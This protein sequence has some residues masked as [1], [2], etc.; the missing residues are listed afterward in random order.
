[1]KAIRIQGYAPLNNI[2]GDLNAVPD[3]THSDKNSKTDAFIVVVQ[4][5]FIVTYSQLMLT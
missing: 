1:L 3:A 5:S 2:S 4:A